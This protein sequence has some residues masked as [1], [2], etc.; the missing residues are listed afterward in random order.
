M[1][2]KE[3][4]NQYTPEEVYLNVVEVAANADVLFAAHSDVLTTT[5]KIKKLANHRGRGFCPQCN[6][7]VGC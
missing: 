2:Q 1:S 7:E 4:K 3:R 6:R 5:T